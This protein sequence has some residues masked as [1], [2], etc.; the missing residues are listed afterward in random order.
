MATHFKDDDRR[1]QAGHQNTFWQKL[2]FGTNRFFS[3]GNIYSVMA[4]ALIWVVVGCGQ[5]EIDVSHNGEST[6]QNSGD[7]SSNQGGE[8][9]GV[10][11]NTAPS[12]EAE[13]TGGFSQP[14]AN[15][16]S[17]SDVGQPPDTGDAP[18]DTG[19]DPEDT[20]GDS[21]D[22]AG[23]PEDTGGDSEDTGGDPE[24][25]GDEPEDTGGDDTC[26]YGVD[27]NCPINCEHVSQWDPNW[28][29][30]AT[31]MVNEINNRR[32]SGANCDGQQMAPAGELAI[33]DSLHQ[34]ARC[35]SQ[36]MASGDFIATQGSDNS[37]SRDRA[38]DA[39]YPVGM[40][41]GIVQG[42]IESASDLIAHLMVF[43]WTCS[44]L[45]DPDWEHVG[46]AVVDDDGSNNPY[47]TIKLGLT[48]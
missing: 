48:F 13:D 42:Q 17:Q 5:G 21:E 7:H 26:D 1:T 40:V 25:T 37:N 10:A 14:D 38:D 19:G 29:S 3:S 20:G 22:T 18:E 11:D 45:M 4:I 35:H 2:A 31:A 30:M 32:S 43:E 16:S 34:A 36:D 39:G 46:V 15:G 47:W 12:P 24:D 44:D 6:Q 23:D 33:H 41:V 8:D 27:P 9:A 28:I